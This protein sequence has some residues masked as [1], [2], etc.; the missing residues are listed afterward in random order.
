[1]MLQ[2]RTGEGKA[3]VL[4][5]IRHRRNQKCR[6][7][8]RNLRGLR[9]CRLSIAPVDIVYTHH[10]RQKQRI[11][12]APFQQLGEFYP[13]A[14]ICIFVH[15]VVWVYPQPRGLVDYAVHMKGVEVNAL[16]HWVAS[17]KTPGVARPCFVSKVYTFFSQI[18]TKQYHLTAYLTP[19]SEVYITC[20]LSRGEQH[21]VISKES[22][23]SEAAPRVRQSFNQPAEA[24]VPLSQ[25]EKVA[26]V[27][28][29]DQEAIEVAQRLAERFL[30]ESSVR[31][32][33][34]RLP[35]NEVE[36]FSQSG[37]W[38]ISVPK[39]YGGAGVSDRKSVV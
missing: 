19:L 38:G 23:M 21:G 39:E 1:M 15:L 36:E 16:V 29:D 7:V 17:S 33:E 11:E 32:R 14:K 5:C 26:H 10:I 35:F 37:L 27:I 22:V 28:R 25:R 24:V 4:S 30:Q 13:G 20:L 9:H 34:R 31:D 2:H 3:Q 8:D 6:V 12:L 18:E